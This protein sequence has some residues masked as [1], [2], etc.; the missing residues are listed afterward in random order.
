M[1]ALLTHVAG[2]SFRRHSTYRVATAAAVLE[3]TVIS[4]LRGLVYV[5][6]VEASGSVDLGTSE[7]ITFAFVSGMI[8]SSFWIV[9]PMEIGERIRSGDVITDLYRPVDFQAWWLASEAGRCAFALLAKGAPQLVL[10]MVVFDL[11]TPRSL[12]SLLLF[13]VSVALAFLVV[14]AWKFTVALVGFWLLDV[15]GITSL[16]G[17]LVTVTSGALLPLAL[18]PDGIGGALRWLP[19]AAMITTPFELFAGGVAVAPRLATQAAW[20]IVLLVVGRVV[21][22]RAVAKVVVQGG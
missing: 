9:A 8:E 4:M 1:T 15:R 19:P 21:L 11:A 22:A 10:G 18:L 13:V 20:A 2:T 14:F 3:N 5:A 12:G 17:A 6:V 16:A 7:A